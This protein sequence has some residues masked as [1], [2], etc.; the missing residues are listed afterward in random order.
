MSVSYSE[1]PIIEMIR[2]NF[3]YTWRRA[4]DAHNY[5]LTDVMLKPGDLLTIS[6]LAET[7]LTDELYYSFQLGYDQKSFYQKE[8]YHTFEITQA[9]ISRSIAVYI[10]LVRKYRDRYLH[11]EEDSIQFRYT[12]VRNN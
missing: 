4:V 8:P 10:R 9:H 5:V 11:H 3:G 1:F 7:P 12:V 6:V 2:D